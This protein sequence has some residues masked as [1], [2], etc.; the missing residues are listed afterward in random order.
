MITTCIRYILDEQRK[1]Y[2]SGIWT[3]DL[4]IDMPVRLP[5]ELTT[6]RDNIWVDQ[7]IILLQIL[8]FAFD[9]ISALYF[10]SF[11]C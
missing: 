1:I 6:E 10:H 9:N 3:C 2:L 4:W 5:T 8:P 11:H 7:F